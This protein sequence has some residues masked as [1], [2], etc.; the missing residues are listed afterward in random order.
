[1]CVMRAVSGGGLQGEGRGVYRCAVPPLLVPASD[2]QDT[3]IKVIHNYTIPL[4]QKHIQLHPQQSTMNSFRSGKNWLSSKVQGHSAQA[5]K[6][7]N[8]S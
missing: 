7:T 4:S 2:I 5:K 3:T 8:K 6:E 1:M